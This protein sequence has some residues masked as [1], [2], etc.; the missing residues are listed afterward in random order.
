MNRGDR[1][2]NLGTIA[3]SG[4]GAFLE[5]LSGD[6]RKDVALIGRL[7]VGFYAAFMVADTIEVTSSKAGDT[8]S[9]EWRA[10]GKGRLTIAE[11]DAELSGPRIV[12]NRREK[13]GEFRETRRL[14]HHHASDS[15]MT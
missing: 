5:Q 11:G 12:L 10:D 9:W 13:A 2:E 3:R 6:A 7:G 4:T 1:V 15:G 14:R 8:Q